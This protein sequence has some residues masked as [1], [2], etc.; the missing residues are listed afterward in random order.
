M[1]ITNYVN[2]NSL[3]DIPPDKTVHKPSWCDVINISNK[4][5]LSQQYTDICQNNEADN[6][7]ILMINPDE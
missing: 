3:S 6:K 2:N 4:Q 5:E 7:W 1:I